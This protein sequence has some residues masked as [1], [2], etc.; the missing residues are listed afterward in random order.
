MFKI[1]FSLIIQQILIILI[2]GLLSTFGL[3]VLI[4]SSLLCVLMLALTTT[5]ETFRDVPLAVHWVYLALFTIGLIL[6]MN[7]INNSLLILGL[8]FSIIILG[9]LAVWSTW[10]DYE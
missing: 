4:I 1:L 7:E 8:A 3:A 6:I 5:S 10:M 2:C 9:N